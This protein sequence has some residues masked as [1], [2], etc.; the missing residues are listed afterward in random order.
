LNRLSIFLLFMIVPAWL[1]AQRLVLDT[2]IVTFNPD[3]ISNHISIG[4]IDT[5]LD[6]RG[7]EDPALLDISEK[8]QYIFVPVDQH[9]LA[10]RPVAEVIHN[11]LKGEHGDS[12]ESMHLR[13]RHLD[14]SSQR[15]LHASVFVYQTGDSIGE[16]LY[17]CSIPKKNGQ[18]TKERYHSLVEQLVFRIGSDL[19]ETN[20]D[21]IQSLTNYRKI[22]KE[23]PWMQLQTGSGMSVLAGGDFLIDAYLTF[24]FPE[25]KKFRRQSVGAMRYRRM[26]RFESIEWGLA[27]DWMT[28]RY[29]PDWVVRFKSQLMFGLNRWN[30]METF[31]HKL[32]DGFLLDFSFGQS[33]HYH[34]KNSRSVILGLGLIENAYYIYSTGFQFDAGLTIQVGVQL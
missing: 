13:L 31:K 24:V 18:K 6:E 20:S 17:E 32:Y 34:P 26:D 1:C 8:N 30:D 15:K 5:V 2:L 4:L 28:Y 21:A 11:G 27:S 3:S 23:N 22:S 12:A 16:L 25:I 19:S 14:F 9:I 33:I 29:H 7:V 10:D